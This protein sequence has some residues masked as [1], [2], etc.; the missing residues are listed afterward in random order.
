MKKLL[1]VVDM[2]NDFIDGSL[3]IK[4][5]QKIVPAVCNKIKEYMKA[6]DDIILTMDTH[7]TNYLETQEGKKLPVKHCIKGT[8]GWKINSLVAD[9]A[10]VITGEYGCMVAPNP[11]S[12]VKVFEKPTFAGLEVAEYIKSQRYHSI[13]VIGLMTDICVVSNALLLKAHHLEEEILVDESC[14]AGTSQEGH[15]SAI[16]VMKIC[17]ISIK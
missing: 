6:G 4:E 15:N 8:E 14:C 9:A 17:H 3:G 13:E 11:P 12:K 2:Q 10:G 16:N 7:D 5:A 1:L